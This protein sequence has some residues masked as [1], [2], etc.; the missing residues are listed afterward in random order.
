MAKI[1]IVEDYL[2]LLD[3]FSIFLKMNDFEVRSISYQKEVQISIDSFSPDL[4]LL[5]VMLGGDDGRDICRE[6][7]KKNKN[8]SVILIS[9]NPKLLK[10]YKEYGADD[11]IEKPFDNVGILDKINKVFNT[12]L[13]L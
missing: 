8:V 6:I 12:K 10:K 4:V 1:L 11:I 2:D 7:K 5:D 9:A 3:F 13:L